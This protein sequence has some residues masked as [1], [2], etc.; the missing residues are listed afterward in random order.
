M[1]KMHLLVTT[2]S[3][4]GI[5]VLANGCAEPHPVVVAPP[6]YQAQAVYPVQ[7]EYQYQYAPQTTYQTQQPG[8]QTTYPG[9]PYTSAQNGVGGEVIGSPTTPQA[10]LPPPAVTN[11]QQIPPQQWATPGVTVAQA[12]PPPQAEA[13]PISPGPGY[14]WTPGYWAWQGNNWVWIGGAW[15]VRP[16]PG[17]VW[18]PG[19]WVRH[20]HGWIWVGGHWR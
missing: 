13:I 10:A 11:Y 15:V 7:P 9:M 3:I 1:R 8:F 20:G 16:G 4:A 17:V 2:L 19:H 5:A 18:V 12:P 6:V 14:Y